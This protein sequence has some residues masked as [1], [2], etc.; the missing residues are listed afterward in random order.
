MT[1]HTTSQANDKTANRPLDTNR[2]FMDDNGPSFI[3]WQRSGERLHDA[4]YCSSRLRS[5]G[6]P[7]PDDRSGG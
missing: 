3:E 5:R 4:R 7:S 6:R 1:T 2:P